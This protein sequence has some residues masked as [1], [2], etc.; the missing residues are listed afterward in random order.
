VRRLGLYLTA[1][2]GAGLLVWNRSDAPSTDVL[3]FT[4]PSISAT[5]K[6]IAPP[7]SAT[8][9]SASSGA[10][11]NSAPV[12]KP[13]IAPS[14][15]AA[16]NKPP[17]P[18]ISPTATSPLRV[19]PSVLKQDQ[20]AAVQKALKS[21]GG[22]TFVRKDP[23]VLHFSHGDTSIEMRYIFQTGND[24]DTLWAEVALAA[25]V[26]KRELDVRIT[27][28]AWDPNNDLQRAREKVAQDR[29]MS[30]ANL[31]SV[32]KEP[33]FYSSFDGIVQDYRKH[34]I[35]LEQKKS[36]SNLEQRDDFRNSVEYIPP[37][38]TSPML[39]FTP[40]EAQTQLTEVIAQKIEEALGLKARF[41]APQFR[42]AQSPAPQRPDGQR[43]NGP[44][45]L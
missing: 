43:Y 38:A 28:L 26:D 44:T 22:M 19:S 11:T 45:T 8:P 18:L 20:D 10:I 2:L 37:F 12:P 17:I 32:F 24:T 41:P 6:S 13:S 5:T 16:S 30:V 40:T 4:T 7:P 34:N 39:G 14:Q 36:F 27:L 25:P 42:A 35:R 3:N 1:A 23:I 29:N 21:I 9:T 15:T 31:P 33:W